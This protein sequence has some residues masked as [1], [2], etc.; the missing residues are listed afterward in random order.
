MKQTL[1]SGSKYIGMDDRRNVLSGSYVAMGRVAGDPGVS[2]LGDQQEAERWYRRN[3]AFLESLPP[4]KNRLGA[5]GFTHGYIASLKAYCGDYAGELA[6]Q[7]KVL[8]IKLRVIQMAP[9]TMYDRRELAIA[10]SNTGV[11]LMD[12]GDFASALEHFHTA[13]RMLE[14]LTAADPKDAELR[15]TQTNKIG[16]AHV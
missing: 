16:R 7:R 11:G 13:G 9:V 3:I 15:I 5:I 1:Y 14:S 4:D 10:Y 2:N 8:E 6:E 12:T